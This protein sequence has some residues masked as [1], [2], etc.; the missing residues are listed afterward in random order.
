[1]LLEDYRSSKKIE[2]KLGKGLACFRRSRTR[3]SSNHGLHRGTYLRGMYKQTNKLGIRG[4][5]T[6]VQMSI[7]WICQSLSLTTRKSNKLKRLVDLNIRKLNKVDGQIKNQ[8]IKHFRI[9][10]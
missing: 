6:K 10:C 5:R 8:E 1:M 2:E 4:V 9:I 7:G 3:I